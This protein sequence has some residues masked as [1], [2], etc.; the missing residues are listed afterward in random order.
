MVVEL[1]ESALP[2]YWVTVGD[3]SLP[4]TV[5]VE[6]TRL[7]GVEDYSRR[8]IVYL[9]R[10]APPEDPILG[11]SDDVIS[12]RFLDAAARSFSPEF[13]K[14]LATHLFRA[15]G[16]QPIVPPGWGRHRPTVRTSIPGLF[17]ANMAQIYPWDRGINYSLAL[18]EDAAAT[19]LKDMSV[20]PVAVNS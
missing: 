16:A 14:P 7:V 12:R 17:A 19:L 4:F 9:G 8:T 10:Y 3:S 5:A 11:E 15:P 20:Q 6:H 13:A 1:A 18:G 2:Y